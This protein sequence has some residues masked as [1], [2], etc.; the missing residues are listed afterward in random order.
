M[1]LRRRRSRW[2]CGR[3]FE[4][5]G[6]GSHAG[7]AKRGFCIFCI[8]LYCEYLQAGAG[9]L[10]LQFLYTPAFLEL[11]G[12]PTGLHTSKSSRVF[13][14]SIFWGRFPFDVMLHVVD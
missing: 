12:G 3:S 13:P 10:V 11:L 6:T 8:L 5:F 4:D 2:R 9:H 7:A 1:R 14:N